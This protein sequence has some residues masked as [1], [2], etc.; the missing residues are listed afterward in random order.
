MIAS[1]WPAAIALKGP[2]GETD[3][4]ALVDFCDYERLTNLAWHKSRNGYAVR[5]QW[6]GDHQEGR[7]MHREVLQIAKGDRHV[8]HINRNRLDNRRIN[9]RLVTKA[10]DRQNTSGKKVGASSPYRGV[11][12][13]KRKG[14][15]M[16][17]AKLDGR[18]HFIRYSKDELE[19][20]QAASDWRKEHMPYS[21]EPEAVAPIAA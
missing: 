8:D 6:C 2:R 1:V 4:V 3:A 13:D 21:N 16:A 7:Y 12:W 5:N 18:M 11:C 17:K 10:Q 19:A 20:A 14:L 15:W 9:L